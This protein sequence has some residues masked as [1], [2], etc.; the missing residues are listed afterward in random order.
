M[1]TT[2]C[3]VSLQ[4]VRSG[5]SA[6]VTVCGELDL[7]TAPVLEDALEPLLGPGARPPLRHLVLDLAGVTFA[8][9]VG[10]TP[11]LRAAETMAERGDGLQIRG[12][13]PPVR[14]LLR[15]LQPSAVACPGG[16]RRWGRRPPLAA[17]GARH[18]SYRGR[19]CASSS[20]VAGSTTTGV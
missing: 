5:A 6:F 17:P 18:A 13:R 15:L 9:V 14:Q 19:S 1:S 8:D 20:P 3:D 4:V 16:T 11:V 2:E 10:L 7:S 12:E